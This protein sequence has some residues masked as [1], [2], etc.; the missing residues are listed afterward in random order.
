VSVT[1]RVR[2]LGKR[3]GE[4]QA[5]ADVSFDAHE[6]QMVAVVGPNGAG[7]TTLL[8]I[9]AG[10]QSPSSGSVSGAPG[11]GREVG[12]APQQPALYSK[13]TVAE[14]MRLFARLEQ[15]EDPDAEVERMLQQTGL[16]S[17]AHDLLGELSGGNRQRVN[18]A[19]ALLGSPPVLALDE[20]S[21][22]LDP[23]QRERLWGF[24]RELAEQGTCV[25]FSTHNVVEA[26]R[27]GDRVVVLDEG[28]MLFDGTPQELLQR[29][30]A[31]TQGDFEQAFV[32]F[33]ER[34]GRG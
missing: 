19:V 13:L 24:V 28:R 7:K 22:A 25:L 5:L 21:S 6:R 10:T 30:P 1:L 31:G 29:A 33:V 4:L 23:G 14:N 12:W 15:V 16:D 9:I 2:A 26:E 34:E 32:A 3:F 18:V 11:G 17:R 20:P 27:H 8:S